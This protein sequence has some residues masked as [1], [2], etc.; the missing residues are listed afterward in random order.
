MK[1]LFEFMKKNAIID[2][3]FFKS[4]RIQR[5]R[6][7]ERQIQRETDTERQKQRDRYRERQILRETKT[8]K[9]KQKN[10]YRGTETER[11][12]QRNI[13]RDRDR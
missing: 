7:R 5:D 11:Q 1:R 12:K 3:L 9:Q 6:Y 13:Q 4:G 8:E 2:N 10:K